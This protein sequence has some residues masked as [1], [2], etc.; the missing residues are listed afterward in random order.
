MGVSL[1]AIAGEEEVVGALAELAAEAL[2]EQHFEVRLIVY[3][4][5]L[6]HEKFRS[7]SRGRRVGDGASWSHASGSHATGSHASGALGAGPQRGRP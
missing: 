3:D 7:W 4:Q 2:A 5:D 1:L 6:R